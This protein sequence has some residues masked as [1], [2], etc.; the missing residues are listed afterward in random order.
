LKPVFGKI[1]P[2]DLRG[3]AEGKAKEAIR[4]IAERVV[5]FSALLRSEFK[6]SDE[7]PEDEGMTET[8]APYLDSKFKVLETSTDDEIRYSAKA[9]RRLVWSSYFFKDMAN[10]GKLYKEE[11]APVDRKQD[12]LAGRIAYAKLCE[13]ML[14]RMSS[15]QDGN[16][17]L[18]EIDITSFL[19]I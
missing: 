2:E 16:P 7:L 9:L 4:R 15:D 17:I 10:G 6:L 12:L 3:F 19:T 1:N 14:P 11:K 18:S 5:A 8:L 13:G